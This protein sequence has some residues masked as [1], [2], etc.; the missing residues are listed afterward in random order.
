MLKLRDQNMIEAAEIEAMNLEQE[1]ADIMEQLGQH[2]II[3]NDQNQPQDED[4]G[5]EDS[6]GSDSTDLGGNNE[7]ENSQLSSPLNMSSEQQTGVSQLETQHLL[8][9]QSL[10]SSIQEDENI[11]LQNSSM[12]DEH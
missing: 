9:R 11:R 4:E 1:E 2:G 5:D 3:Q 12:V 7:S 8:S 6:S 10:G